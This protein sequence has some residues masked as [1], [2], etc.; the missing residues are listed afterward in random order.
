VNGGC[1]LLAVIHQQFDHLLFEP[2]FCNEEL[3]EYQRGGSGARN[4]MQLQMHFGA[5]FVHPKG[6]RPSNANQLTAPMLLVRTH[7]ES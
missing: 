2:A 5:P 4:L 7:G 3:T 1:F 6:Y